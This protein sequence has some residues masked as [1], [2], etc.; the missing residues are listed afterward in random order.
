[1]IIAFTEMQ[2][3]SNLRWPPKSNTFAKKKYF[4]VNPLKT[5]RICFI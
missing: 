1:M 2:D 5:K 3:D 4:T